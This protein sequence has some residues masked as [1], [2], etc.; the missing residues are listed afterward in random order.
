MTP[1]EELASMLAAAAL[2]L[3][4]LLIA[5]GAVWLLIRLTG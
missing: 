4:C 3:A 1:N 2:K 5:T